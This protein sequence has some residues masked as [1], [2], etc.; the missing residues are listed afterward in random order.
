[1]VPLLPV[2]SA[3]QRA[4]GPLAPVH[5]VLV[6]QGEAGEVQPAAASVQQFVLLLE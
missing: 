3:H 6:V 2:V 1:M 4:F 5:H